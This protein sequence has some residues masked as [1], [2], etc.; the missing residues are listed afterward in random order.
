MSLLRLR[1]KPLRM[2][3]ASKGRPRKKVTLVN[4]Y[5]SKSEARLADQL[6]SLGVPFE[7]EKER[8]K[9]RVERNASYL[10][11][12]KLANGIFIEVKGWFKPKDRTK[13]LAIKRSNPDLDVRFV[14]DKSTTKISKASATTYGDWCE[15]HGFLFAEKIIPQKWINK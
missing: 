14:F 11:D 12:F 6:V 10:P 9:Y 5:R 4:G 15:K 13:H 2:P 7:Y 1:S 8:V 3:W